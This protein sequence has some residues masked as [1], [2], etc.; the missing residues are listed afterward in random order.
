MNEI[1]TGSPNREGRAD[2]TAIVD[3]VDEKERVIPMQLPQ[4][5]KRRYRVNR[6]LLCLA[7]RDNHH[8]AVTIRAG[9][10]FEVIGSAEDDRFVVVEVKGD[11][12]LIFDSDLKEFGKLVLDASGRPPT[13]RREL[14]SSGSPS[15]RWR[16]GGRYAAKNTAV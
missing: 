6:P 15:R 16:D 4:E 5:P 9:Q 8:A 14:A 3:K 11:Q 7:F 13:L 10:V 2:R 1:F 12:F